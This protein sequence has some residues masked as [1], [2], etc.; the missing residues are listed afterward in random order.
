MVNIFNKH[1]LDL[2][3]SVNFKKKL[4]E[5]IQ[6]IENESAVEIVPVFVER[7]SDYIDFRR[8]YA[9]LLMLLFL[10]MER[11]LPVGSGSIF[12]DWGLATLLS[13]LAFF[14]WDYCP[15]YLLPAIPK[16]E[17]FKR[18]YQGANAS[19]VKNEVFATRQRS[20]IL[21]YISLLEKSVLILADKGF[22]NKVP[23]TLWTELS[24]SLAQDF[25][26]ENPGHS[27]FKALDSFKGKFQSIFPREAD[28]PN[29]LP[30]NLRE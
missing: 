23:D 10:L 13:T 27:F 11:F 16:E 14:F 20:G 18:V 30:D 24:Q 25:D 1:T 12:S 19:F 15:Q 29:E 6:L 5:Q 26:A 28:D 17:R 3:F 4:E 9:L 21:I 7:S 8:F 2:K 22:K